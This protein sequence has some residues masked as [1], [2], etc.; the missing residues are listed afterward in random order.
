MRKRPISEKESEVRGDYDAVTVVPRKPACKEVVLHNC[1]FQADLKTPFVTHTH[2]C[3]DCVFPEQASNEEVYAQT[4]EPLV[5]IALNGG[6]AT[7]FMFGQT[8]SGKTFTMTAI[9]EFAA[10]DMF[11]SATE[12]ADDF[13]SLHLGH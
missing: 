8:G 9:E 10:R 7:M 4:A 11:A 6:I 5:Q 13:I 12:P 2:F 3:F 1:Q